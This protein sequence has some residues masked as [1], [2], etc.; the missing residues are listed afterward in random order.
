M[1]IPLDGIKINGIEVD[2]SFAEAFEMRATRL[3]ITAIDYHWA[4]QAAENM[5]G[6]ATSVIGCGIEAGIERRL[7][8][9]ETPDGRS[10]YSVLIFAMSTKDLAKHLGLRIGQCILTCP[11]TAVFSGI[12]S[13]KKVSKKIL[14]GD[15]IRYFGDGYQISKIVGDKRY[16]RIP[17]MD[18]EFVCE[19][20]ASV[21][22]AIGGGNF[23]IMG[24]SQAEVIQACRAGVE[25]MSHVRNIVLPFPGGGVRSGSKVGSRYKRLNAST[26]DPYCPT[27]RGIVDSSLK[28]GVESA[29]E[30]VIDGLSV[31]DVINA[32][33]VGIR[34][35][36]DLGA[37]HGIIGITAGN[38]D[39]KLGNYHFH[40]WETVE[41]DE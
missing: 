12:E 41:T 1:S 25:A 38:Y 2:N 36:C 9:H 32:M 22:P 24:R 40:L 15:Y 28:P 27:L 18:G 26:N 33:R 19:D 14:L 17:V 3:I 31:Q 4:R 35:V 20:K 13:D 29:M 10:G 37:Q 11:T 30:I 7:A 39:G 5:T 16:W 8:T 6:F 21:V 23:I 34:A